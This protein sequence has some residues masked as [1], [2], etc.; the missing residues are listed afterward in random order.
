[1][2]SIFYMGRE[3]RAE[4]T[5]PPNQKGESVGDEEKHGLKSN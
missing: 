3:K 1:M 2:A 5:K 4:R